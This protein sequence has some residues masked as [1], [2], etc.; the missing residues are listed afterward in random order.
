MPILGLVV[1]NE[2]NVGAL[3]GHLGVFMNWVN[4]NSGVAV[5]FAT[6]RKLETFGGAPETHESGRWFLEEFHL[7]FPGFLNG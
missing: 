5:H 2:F 7:A 4:F 1:F 6:L 3:A